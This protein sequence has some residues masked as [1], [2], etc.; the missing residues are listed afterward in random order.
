MR[1][2]ENSLHSGRDYWWVSEWVGARKNGTEKKSTKI[3]HSLNNGSGWAHPLAEDFLAFDTKHR[4]HCL[5]P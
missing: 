5:L 1:W 2:N 3:K 4:L